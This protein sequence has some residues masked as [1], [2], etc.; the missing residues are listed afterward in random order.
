M[1]KKRV[2][3]SK[4]PISHQLSII[5]KNISKKLNVSCKIEISIWCHN[6]DFIPEN[7]EYMIATVPNYR[8][9]NHEYFKSW[10]ELLKYYRSLMSS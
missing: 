1:K 6:S 7:I 10:P 9:C 3:N 2:G 5:T 4:E 8:G